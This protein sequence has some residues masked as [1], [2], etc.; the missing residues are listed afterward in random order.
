MTFPRVD[1]GPLHFDLVGSDGFQPAVGGLEGLE[2]HR[3]WLNTCLALGRGR[4]GG[5]S[6][7]RGWGADAPGWRWRQVRFTP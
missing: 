7:C 5:S 4:T 6:P 1:A 2:G 3:G